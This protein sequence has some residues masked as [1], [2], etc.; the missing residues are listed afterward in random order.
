[1]LRHPNGAPRETLAEKRS[2]HFM[3]SLPLSVTAWVCGRQARHKA[4]LVGAPRGMAV[5]GETLGIVGFL[6]FAGCA[7]FISAF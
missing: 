1:M 4:V 2:A 6:A 7:A 5:A 3:L